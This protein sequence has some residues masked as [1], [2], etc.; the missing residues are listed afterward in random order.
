VDRQ[1]NSWL[2]ASFLADS[3]NFVNNA[4][5]EVEIITKTEMGN[6][7]S[8]ESLIKSEGANYVLAFVKDGKGSYFLKNVKVE[9]GRSN[10][11]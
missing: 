4:Y 5:A 6:S 1:I 7:V 3:A 11:G 2:Q 10:N 8:E 9:I